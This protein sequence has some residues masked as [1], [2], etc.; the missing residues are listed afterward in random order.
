MDAPNVP[1]TTQSNAEIEH[2][3]D[4]PSV[5]QEADNSLLDTIAIQDAFIF[6]QMLEPTR[7]WYKA[8][9]QVKEK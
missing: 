9:L 3:K 1:M 7:H 2:E 6:C 5:S 4:Y 8:F